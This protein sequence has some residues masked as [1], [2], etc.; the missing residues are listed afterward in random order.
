[1]LFFK[2]SQKENQCYDWQ[3]VWLSELKLFWKQN[4][5]V[6]KRCVKQM[7]QNTSK[8]NLTVKFTYY[9]YSLCQWQCIYKIHKQIQTI[10]SHGPYSLCT[11]LST[12]SC[13][14]NIYKHSN[15][16][17]PIQELLRSWLI[18]ILKF[19]KLQAIHDSMLSL[20]NS[21]SI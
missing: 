15:S 9:A 21:C 19:H 7:L 18:Y 16:N 13:K 17:V 4:P 20:E 6:F 3:K 2:P 5:E 8:I 1:M 11:Y 14:H 10:W 12:F